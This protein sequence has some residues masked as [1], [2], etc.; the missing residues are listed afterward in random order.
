MDKVAVG[1]FD[2]GAAFVDG[3]FGQLSEAPISLFD[4]G[5]TCSDAT[6]DGASVRQGTFFRL[7]AHLDRFFSSLEKLRMKISYDRAQVREILHNC[8]RAGNQ[9]D[10]YVA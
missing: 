9:Q 8:V 6:Y 10:A 5:F 4:W 3:V 7:D 1:Q 2:G